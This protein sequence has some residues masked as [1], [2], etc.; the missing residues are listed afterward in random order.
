MTN[1]P[2]PSSRNPAVQLT[3]TKRAS[4]QKLIHADS[5]RVR[6]RALILLLSDQGHSGEHISSLLGLSRRMVSRTRTRWREHNLKGLPDQPRPGRPPKVTDAYL[7]ELFRC[8][9]LDPR[10]LGYAFT[11]WTAPRLAAYLHEKTHILISA[12]WVA[13]LLRAR[14]YV[15]RRT[16]QTIRNKQNPKEVKRAKQELLE[17]KKRA[18]ERTPASNFGS[19]MES[20]SISC[21]SLPTLGENKGNRYG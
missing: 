4:L 13:E 18:S 19:A 12:D 6:S 3:E 21:P 9:A 7:T 17:L 10:S 11:R 1:T 20:S 15:W 16:K 14:H 8:V 2:R 5:D